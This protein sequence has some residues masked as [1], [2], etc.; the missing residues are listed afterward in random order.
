VNAPYQLARQHIGLREIPGPQHEPKIVQMFADVGH[1]WVKDDE[2]AWCA[3]F[4]GSML[5]RAGFPHTGMLT[6]RSY[7]KWG[8]EVPLT[9]A[10]PGD[11]VIFSRG[12]SSWQGHV[13]FFVGQTAS[14]IRVLGG[15]QG[16]MVNEALYSKSSLLGVRR[17]P[18]P[19]EPAKEPATAPSFWTALVDFIVKLLRGSKP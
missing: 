6:A 11:L 19:A 1:A 10:Q 5:K 9:S 8:E 13:G 7:L 17:L 4:V 14:H 16:N 18:Q 12:T 3:A 2:T 15:N